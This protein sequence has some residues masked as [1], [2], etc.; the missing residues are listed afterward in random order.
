MPPLTNTILPNNGFGFLKSTL[1]R[2][3][4]YGSDIRRCSGGGIMG[5][6]I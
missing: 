5:L 4:H 3:L 1:E 2:I 6:F